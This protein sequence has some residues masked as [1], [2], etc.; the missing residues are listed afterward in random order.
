MIR[1]LSAWTAAALLIVGCGGGGGDDEGSGGGS[2]QPPLTVV[3]PPSQPAVSAVVGPG[4]AALSIPGVVWVTFPANSLA[5]TTVQVSTSA[6]PDAADSFVM[7]VAMLESRIRTYEIRINT[8]GSKPAGDTH[9]SIAAPAQLLE[10]VSAP[11]DV[12]VFALISQSSASHDIRS[13]EVIPSV[14]DPAAKA[15]NFLVTPAQRIFSALWTHNGTYEAV[16][17]LA[18]VP[19]ESQTSWLPWR[20]FDGFISKAFAQVPEVNCV[21]IPILEDY[22]PTSGFGVPRKDHD[23]LGIDMDAD[24]GDAVV[25]AAAG[26]VVANHYDTV[27]GNY[28][29]VR[30]S[31]SLFS[32]Y[33]HLFSTEAKFE[34]ARPVSLGPLKMGKPV[35][36]AKGEIIGTAGSTGRSTGP[37]LHFELRTGR[38]KSQADPTLRLRGMFDGVYT[39][40]S[41][42]GGVGHHDLM[43]VELNK[44]KGQHS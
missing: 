33:M 1:C 4:G 19:P 14:F 12:Q 30:H 26:E 8:G 6:S 16:F 44:V 40:F 3:P 7:A 42:I 11:S 24:R 2:S 20:L 15:F 36:V 18:E 32:A 38:Y 22:V 35:G 27:S 23:H 9:L 43:F 41:N 10:A 29:I 31:R 28:I 34:P 13:F 39:G 5:A 17:L 25:A 37:H 21:F